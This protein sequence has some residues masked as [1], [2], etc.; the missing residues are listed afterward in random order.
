MV[1]RIMFYFFLFVTFFISV[2]LLFS[3]PQLFIKMK[4][5]FP[6]I[7]IDDEV[8]TYINNEEK[9]FTS[10]EPNAKKQIIWHSTSNK[11]TEYSIVFIHGSFATGF[12]QKETLIKI[13]N[14]L[15]ANLFISRLSGHGVR[16][17]ETKEISAND[18]IRDTAEAVAVGNKIGDKVILIGFSAGSGLAML[19]SQD[20]KLKN[21]IHSLVLIAPPTL[22]IRPIIVLASIGLLFKRTYEFN[23]PKFN[24]LSYEEWGPYWVNKFDSSL[25]RAFWKVLSS[26][27]IRNDLAQV[28]MLIFYDKRDRVVNFE[29]VEKIFDKWS[30]PKKI[31]DIKAV[32]AGRN[33]HNLIGVLNATQDDLFVNEIYEWIYVNS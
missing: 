13:A 12:Q 6:N 9:K 10:L 24:G 30:G 15:N 25:P 21:L 8:V 33:K 23:F 7:Q 17:E 26:I 1:K 27:K 31:I 22:K 16:Y 32:N 28:P 19:A 4:I 3:L 29:R 20:E 11:K 14:K 2:V 5:T 18:F